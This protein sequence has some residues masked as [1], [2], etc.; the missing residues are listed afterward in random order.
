MAKPFTV[1][2]RLGISFAAALLLGAAI[3]ALS[4][5]GTFF[6][7][8]LA[9]SLLSWVSIFSLLSV[10][11]WAGGGKLLLWML[12][13]AFGLRLALGIGF[14]L[15]LPEYGFDEP[16]QNAGYLFYDAYRRDIESFD[17]T[18]S[19]AS[20]WQTFALEFDTDQYGGLLILA[21]LIYTYLSPDAHRTFLILL[22]SAFVSALGVPFL[23]KAV[24]LRW[25]ERVASLAAWMLVFYPDHLLFGSSQMREPYLITFSCIAIWGLVVWRQSWRTS[26]ALL[27]VS[28]VGLGVFSSR[29]AVVIAGLLAVWFWLE[30]LSLR[31]RIFRWLGYAGIGLAAL[32]MVY[33]SWEWLRSSAWY[34]LRLT[35]LNSGRVQYELEELQEWLRTPFLVGYGLVQPV[36]PAIIAY[37]TLAVWKFIGVLRALGWYLLAPFLLYGVLA[38]WKA[39]PKSERR[40]LLWFAAAVLVWL[41]ISS[42]RAGGDQWDN[43]RYRTLLLPWMAILAAYGIEWARERRDAWLARLLLIEFIFVGFF[44]SWY[45]SRYLQWWGR[46]SLKAMVVWIVSLSAL[47]AAGGWAWD[48]WRDRRQ[49]M[50]KGS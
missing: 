2:P 14:T 12:A 11:R 41:V 24:R 1:L 5:V 13:L 29:V 23:W 32:A 37:P 9:A 39:H 4:P 44:T 17:L 46:M 42:A 18:K 34:D 36:L 30:Y 16:T 31:S 26:A 38:A 33:L 25:G 35:V 50:V 47:V 45:I 15:L 40:V 27:A 49:R 3:S 10:W 43:P 19:G 48:R 8:W 20:F 22:L 6:P 7:G 28:L 21:G